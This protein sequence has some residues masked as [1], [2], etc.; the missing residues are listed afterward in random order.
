MPREGVDRD[1]WQMALR[2]LLLVVVPGVFRIVICVDSFIASQRCCDGETEKGSSIHC[3]S[4]VQPSLLIQLSARAVKKADQNGFGVAF[5]LQKRHQSGQVWARKCVHLLEKREPKQR[6]SVVRKIQ[7]V[8][9]DPLQL[10]TLPEKGFRLLKSCQMAVVCTARAR[11]MR[12]R[13]R[14]NMIDG[15]DPS[16]RSITIIQCPH[17]ACLVPI[18]RNP[19]LLSPRDTPSF[20]RA[21]CTSCAHPSAPRW[22]LIYRVSS[23]MCVWCVVYQSVFAPGR[24][25]T[26]CW[27]R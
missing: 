27:L 25:G 5:R 13:S 17:G 21:F 24:T 18:C 10:S 8:A 12:N 20:Q 22:N 11:F 14:C 3:V 6:I 15:G 4:N 2:L 26:R 9:I 1:T 19:W 23:T 7:W 16:D